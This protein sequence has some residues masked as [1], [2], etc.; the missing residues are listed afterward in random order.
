MGLQL[1]KRRFQCRHRPTAK[2]AQKPLPEH[3]Q[4]L[5]NNL[6]THH[7]W[8]SLNLGYGRRVP[9]PDERVSLGRIHPH[10]QIEGALGC[11]QPV[12]FLVFTGAFVLDESLAGEGDR[13]SPR[14]MQ[15]G[16]GTGERS[17]SL[18]KRMAQIRLA[19]GPA[20][21][22]TRLPDMTVALIILGTVWMAIPAAALAL[23]TVW[24]LA[25]FDRRHSV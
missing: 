23:A 1:A 5:L 25:R 12:R 15:G 10:G 3:G 11:R 6:L 18:M 17:A 14:R 24:R 7:A 9:F 2:H 13:K 19:E 22:R 4:G 16:V 8:K 21:T 20:M